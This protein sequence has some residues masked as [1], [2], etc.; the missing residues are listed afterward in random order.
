MK[1]KLHFRINGMHCVTC[2]T[3]VEKAIASVEGVKR[4]QVNFVSEKAEAEVDS[5][6]PELTKNIIHA[7]DSEGYK[8]TPYLSQNAIEGHQHMDHSS[9]NYTDVIIAIVFTLPLLAHMIGFY[10]PPYFQLGC[11]SVVQF[12]AGRRFYK[13]AWGSLKS[14]VANMDLLVVLGTSAAYGYSLVAV[15]LGRN[16]LYFEASAV[17]ITLVLIGRLL[18]E[19]A[20]RSANAAVRS[21]MKLT[22]PTALVERDGV[23]VEVLSH[24][25]KKGDHIMVRAWQRIPVDGFIFK[26]TT[27]VDESMITGE[28]VPV[29]KEEG[30]KVIGGS[31]NTSGVFYLDATDVGNHSTLSRM[32][33][34]VEE[35]QSS[36]PPIQKFVDQ[37]ASIFVPV[38][39]LISIITLATWLLMGFGF[40]LALLSAVSVLV[41]A[42]PCAL[43]LATPTAIVVAMGEAAR[44]GLLIK[45]LESL[46]ALRQV[47]LVVFDKTG[48]LTKGEFSLTFSKSF[49]EISQSQM[50][51]LASSLQKGSEHPVAKA[52]LKATKGQKL[53]E[54]ED[55]ISLP[56]KGIQGKMNGSFYSLG[57]EM[58]MNEQTIE[59]PPARKAEQTTIYLAEEGKLLGV[60][61]L[62]DMPRRRARETL[63]TL[64][65]MGLKTVMLT[66]DSKETAQLI[67]EKV[68]IDDVIARLQPKDKINYV[69]AQEQRHH[70]VAMVGDGVNDGP[71][72]AAASVGFAMG[73]GTDV[74]MDAA[75]IT[76]MR[77]DLTLI[78]QAFNLSK[79]TFRIIQENLFW[80]FIFNIV[81]IGFAAF[82]HLSPELAGAAMAASSLLVVTNSLRLKWG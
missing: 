60:F 9:P 50:L 33:Q 57:S 12:W 17:V 14:L 37:V 21:L 45:D 52:F 23:Y 82:G 35:A 39:L 42:C 13:L 8:A 64:N 16:D 53:F 72:L 59:V 62:A 25:I 29:L 19:R 75:P 20:K 24:D 10:I 67:G 2:A 55:F 49:S 48:T 1:K 51:L 7:I 58:L 63:H 44:Q 32:I 47:D 76:L 69:K 11:A 4:A 43:G 38:V 68:G 66:G 73:S 36:R 71:A 78:P 40:Q 30:D 18:E 77:P 74:A 56:G 79:R 65:D 46:E 6:T 70:R 61:Y 27:E 3:R 15:L 28:S 26:G 80:A 54:V 81:G 22:P 5:T 34:M 31:T 41:V